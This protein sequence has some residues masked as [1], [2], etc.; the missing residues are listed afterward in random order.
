MPPMDHPSLVAARDWAQASP[1]NLASRWDLALDVFGVRGGRIVSKRAEVLS[2]SENVLEYDF[3]LTGEGWG[4]QVAGS[5]GDWWMEA[6]RRSVRAEIL[7]RAEPHVESG[8]T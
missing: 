7:D 4:R 5:R 3:A 6:C 2:N 8:T 1:R